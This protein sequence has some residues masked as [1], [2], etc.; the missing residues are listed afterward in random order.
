MYEK[1]YRESQNYKRDIVGID[2]I[3]KDRDYRLEKLREEVD[4][5]QGKFDKLSGENAQTNVRCKSLTAENTRLIDD[6]R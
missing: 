2:E 1:L 3:K 4:Q 6:Y 5:L